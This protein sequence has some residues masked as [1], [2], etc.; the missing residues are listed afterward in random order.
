M[1]AHKTQL[2]GRIGIRQATRCD[3]ASRRKVSAMMNTTRGKFDRR[4]HAACLLQSHPCLMWS[5]QWLINGF[6]DR[7]CGVNSMRP[8]KTKFARPSHTR[9]A[10]GIQNAVDPTETDGPIIR[11]AHRPWRHGGDRNFELTTPGGTELLRFTIG[12]RV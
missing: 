12:N 10:K 11:S 1:C 2:M 7:T 3:S 9:R 6:I 8:A 4:G 5:S